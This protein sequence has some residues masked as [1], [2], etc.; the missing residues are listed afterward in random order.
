MIKKNTVPFVVYPCLI[1]GVCLLLSRP[2]LAGDGEE[3]STT[4]MTAYYKGD[5][6]TAGRAARA[7]IQQGGGAFAH[8]FHGRIHML[9]RRYEAAGKAFKA[10]LK[11]LPNRP[12]PEEQ[13]LK[14][15]LKRLLRLTTSVRV[16]QRQTRQLA[17]TWYESADQAGRALVKAG[18]LQAGTRFL[19]LARSDTDNS[20][21]G[22]VPADLAPAV[23]YHTLLLARGWLPLL[24]G[25]HAHWSALREGFRP[26]DWAPDRQDDMLRL[27]RAESILSL[28]RHQRTLEI[29]IR[30]GAD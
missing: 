20:V 6:A 8:Y 2:G 13:V 3:V 4:A 5:T 9:E 26:V 1:L 18:W 25:P 22:K 19:A 21:D 15:R 7:W 12:G 17:R 10:G 16:R 11:A 14:K 30:S 27:G 28:Q 24:P 23:Q 29:K